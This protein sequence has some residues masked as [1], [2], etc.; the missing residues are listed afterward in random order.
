MYNGTY[1]FKD[2]LSRFRLYVLTPPPPTTI[3]GCMSRYKTGNEEEGGRE[4]REI[5]KITKTSDRPQRKHLQ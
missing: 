5:E 1:G 2:F 4:G 3:L